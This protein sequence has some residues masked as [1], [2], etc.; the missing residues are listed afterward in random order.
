MAELGQD[1]EAVKVLTLAK[2][3][4]STNPD[5]AVTLQSLNAKVAAAPPPPKPK[6]TV[7][8]AVTRKLQF[9]PVRGVFSEK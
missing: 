7:V 8:A 5:V 4:G 1:R 3:L 9:D 2:R 6:P